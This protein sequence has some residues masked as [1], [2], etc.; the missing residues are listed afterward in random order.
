M[1]DGKMTYGTA[2]VRMA[3]PKMIL[4]KGR[5]TPTKVPQV[6]C[7]CGVCSSEFIADAYNVRRIKQKTCS[8]KCAVKLRSQFPDGNEQHPLYSRWLSMRQRCLNPNNDGWVNYGGRGITISDALLSFDGYVE[9]VSKLPNFDLNNTLDRIDNNLGYIEGNLRW[10]TC[11]TQVANQGKRKDSTNPYRGITYNKCHDK[12]I[13]RVNF[14]GETLLSTT[15]KTK[16]DALMARNRFILENGL[17]HPI[18][19]A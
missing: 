7:K 2:F 5:K 18:Q 9:Y 13:A 15:H 17:P 12:W 14:K 8:L 11:S 16:E 4:R 6:V 3:E 10:T 19:E 1:D